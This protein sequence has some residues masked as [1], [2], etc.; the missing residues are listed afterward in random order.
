MTTKQ[1]TLK[2][3]ISNDETVTVVQG[4]VNSRFLEV[5]LVDDNG[6]LDL[7]QKLV[8]IYAKKPD[9][10]IIY[11][12][13]EIID[14]EH[15]IIN[16]KLTSEMSAV[17]GVLED[18]EIRVIDQDGATLKFKGLNIIIKK[19][20]PDTEVESSSEFTALQDAISSTIASGIHQELKNN[21]HQVTAEQAGAAPVDHT[22]S[23]ESITQKPTTIEGYGI[24]DAATKSQGQKADTAIQSTEKGAA[25]GVATLDSNSKLVQL[26]TPSDINAVPT[27]RTINSKPLTSDISLS[28]SDVEALP[29]STFIPTKISDLQNDSGFIS[30]FTET[31]PTVPSWAKAESKPSYNFSELNNKPT[32]LSGYGITDAATSSQGAKADSAIQGIK[33]NGTTIQPNSS[34][35]VNITA[36]NIGAIE[37]I[38]KI[39]ITSS[40]VFNNVAVTLLKIG[41]LV[42]VTMPR[43]TQFLCT[44][45]YPVLITVP[46]GYRPAYMIDIFRASSGSADLNIICTTNGEITVGFYNKT[47]A[48]TFRLGTL[49]WPTD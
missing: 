40:S 43:I 16:V 18:C 21:P 14:Q 26:P 7:T 28:A 4:E 2:A 32:T 3:W 17:S 13:A 31:D 11:N 25:N 34:K 30:E 44:E 49:L 36:S 23:F 20:L 35:V 8:Q 5:T 33:G 1:I 48:Y 6:T 45:D 46:E 47:T 9:G 19:A 22:H 12:D 27:S 10:N 15:G 41:K 39:T 42:M 24:I 38:E 29:D 37:N